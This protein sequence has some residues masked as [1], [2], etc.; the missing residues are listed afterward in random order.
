N[1]I[2]D[3][4]QP[5]H[6]QAGTHRLL[7]NTSSGSASDDNLCQSYTVSGPA[8]VTMESNV[9]DRCKFG[10][11]VD[12][13]AFVH[14]LGNVITNPWV[15]AFDVRAA[16]KLRGTGNRLKTRPSGFT[17]L[18]SVQVGL[19]VARNDGRARVDFGGGDF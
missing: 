2:T 1:T 5:V 16:G 11:R 18:S 13:T 4:S 19:L 15:A 10:V 12:G 6:A 7:A 17:T 14:A 3:I 8:V 9:I